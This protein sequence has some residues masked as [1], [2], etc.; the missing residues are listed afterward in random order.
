VIYGVPIYD[1]DVPRSRL[2]GRYLTHVWVWINTL[3]FDIRDSMCGFRVYPL[4]PTLALLPLPP[5]MDFDVEVMVR[6][7]WAGLKF[8]PILTQVVYP[9][10]GLSHFRLWRDNARISWMHTRLFFGMLLRLP[11][12]LWRKLR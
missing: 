11:V 5:R 6:L 8:Q 3:S 10:G 1:A 9:Q 2:Y 4:P 12:L 7:H